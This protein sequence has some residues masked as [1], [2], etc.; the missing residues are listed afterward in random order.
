[1]GKHSGKHI[2]ASAI[3][4]AALAACGGGGDSATNPSPSTSSST[5]ISGTA[6]T[7]A[8]IP[9]ATVDV[10]CATGGGS[11]TT[12]AD[13]RF[14]ITLQDATRPC[15]LSVGAPD[16]TTL[17]SIVE[18]GS[19][20]EAVANITP[21]TELLAAS[22]AGGSTT[23]FFANFDAAAQA[24]L[25]PETLTEARQSVTLALSGIVD[26][27][28]VD[29]LTDTLVAAT[30]STA[31]N[32]LDQK[33]DALGLALKAAQL[34]VAELSSAVASNTGTVAPVQTILQPAAASCAGLRSGTYRGIDLVGNRTE[35]VQIDAVG[36]KVT[37]PSDG[38]AEALTDERDCR[39]STA[40]SPQTLF[41]SKSGVTVVRDGAAT[42]PG[43]A[44]LLV[45][46]Q[47]FAVSELAGAWNFLGAE[48][49]GPRLPLAASGGT[50]TLDPAGKI[51]QGA[52]CV[53]IDACR[54][55][56][57]SELGTVTPH[58]EGGYTFDS[59]SEPARAFAFKT[60]D[61]EIMMVLVG[62]HG[63]L[64]AGRQQPSVLPQL[65]AV[66]KQ[67]DL[68][69]ND[70]GKLDVPSQGEFTIASV[71]ASSKSYTRVR[72]NGN[73]ESMLLDKP[74]SGL[75]HRPSGS[76]LDVNGQPIAGR[77]I[78]ALGGASVGISAVAQ[79]EAG[80][81]LIFAFSVNKP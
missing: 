61:G 31:G 81:G 62:P 24:K 35:L 74:R 54:D 5:T 73:V 6:A 55:W 33:L 34:T 32:E 17:H 80:P 26:L 38:A 45:P 72:A 63:F 29:P 16:G 23:N 18:S 40:G 57:P 75:F 69:M 76:T 47:S 41:V 13:G 39:F 1:M 66:R 19:G 65:G 48:W 22:I 60:A 50:F 11:T 68:L 71:D 9:D 70:A 43:D 2:L 30:G 64:M 37:Y 12:G 67:W 25:T 44:R 52:D 7:G 8:S 10:K 14:S 15:V 27:S 36:L 49:T 79:L 28:G 53:G 4:A 58:G 46:E 3:A 77:G 59:G 56:D 42:S 21:L 20:T 78:V 51:T